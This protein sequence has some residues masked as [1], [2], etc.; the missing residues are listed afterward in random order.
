MF[1]SKNKQLKIAVSEKCNKTPDIAVMAC[2]PY[3]CS[4]YNI[5]LL[6]GC[7]IPDQLYAR[8][9]ETAM[10]YALY[11][12]V[13]DKMLGSPLEMSKSRVSSMGCSSHGQHFN[14]S[15]NTQ[16]T[17]SALKKTIKLYLSCLNPAKLYAKY[18][19]CIK[20]LGGKA[21]K[22]HFAACANKMIE[23]IKNDISIV[24]IGKIKIAA[25]KLDEAVESLY[26]KLPA[27]AKVSG[28]SVLP[29]HP[30]VKYEC[31]SVDGSG[32]SAV[33]TADYIRN[34]VNNAKVNLSGKKIYITNISDQAW[35]TKKEGIKN[36]KK[37][38][39]YV[40]QKY[41]KLGKEFPKVMGYLSIVNGYT[42]CSG[43]KEIAKSKPDLKAITDKIIKSL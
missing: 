16:G 41:G 28:G 38:D 11:L 3:A 14:I 25:P 20:R 17:L 4:N 40:G 35:K 8:A 10:A 5:C 24:A 33:V 32:M 9:E 6:D 1:E 34:K 27:L 37:I 30:E 39:V 13:R 19:D 15:W 23:S 42:N 31:P 12:Q 43:V 2:I 36:K 22:G 18:S 29:K 21:D 26:S 7:S